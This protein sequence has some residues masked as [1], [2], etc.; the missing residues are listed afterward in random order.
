MRDPQL[1]AQLK[2]AHALLL[3][4]KG[5]VQ[6]GR[7]LLDEA[8]RQYPDDPIVLVNHGS[9]AIHEQDLVVAVET[10]D[11]AV[12]LV[13]PASLPVV[14]LNRSLAL[15]G[16]GR[17]DQA[18]EDYDA[19]L[20]SAASAPLPAPLDYDVNASPRPEVPVEELSQ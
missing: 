1:A 9:L 3:A 4:R 15:R 14:Y 7:R 20:A 13:D 2:S 10:F 6:A 12:N 17:Y 5:Q 11:R 19:Y 8:L 18:R 16:L